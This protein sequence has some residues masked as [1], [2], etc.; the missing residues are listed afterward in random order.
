MRTAK[1]G[2]QLHEDEFQK[3]AKRLKPLS[4]P[5]ASKKDKTYTKKALEEIQTRRR[6]RY[7]DLLNSARKDD[8][9]ALIMFPD[10]DE[11]EIPLSRVSYSF[12]DKAELYE[13]WPNDIQRRITLLTERI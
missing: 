12:K 2:R 10:P 9:A 6:L 11:Y 5:L 4:H 8:M 3:R 7:N 1:H 13:R